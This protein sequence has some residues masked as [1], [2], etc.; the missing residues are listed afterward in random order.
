MLKLSV[1]NDLDFPRGG[2]ISCEVP[3][4]N[5][6]LADGNRPMVSQPDST[7]GI[8]RLYAVAGVIGPNGTKELTV[9][10]GKYSAAQRVFGSAGHLQ[11]PDY[12]INAN[13]L[14]RGIDTLNLREFDT[15]VDYRNF[16]HGMCGLA[17]VIG[18]NSQLQGSEFALG[19]NGPVWAML[20]GSALYTNGA[21]SSIAATIRVYGGLP[22]IELEYRVE[23]P[24]NDLFI[25]LPG[26][27][28]AVADLRSQGDARGKGYALAA[29]DE[30]VWW[31][32]ITGDDDTVIT[33]HLLMEPLNATY[34]ALR[35]CPILAAN[36]S[37]TAMEHWCAM[38]LSPLRV[39]VQR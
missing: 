19:N 24:T 32:S 17:A 10:P 30:L 29:G 27:Q 33:P 15:T 20:Q 3:S 26:E 18:N 31:V 23:P 7:S 14:V 8:T 16:P 28:V 12:A 21:P 2:L 6:H 11:S 38:Q 35:I 22:T 37:I 36:H 39:E 13:S 5:F 4:E 25:A 1:H 9:Y 34:T